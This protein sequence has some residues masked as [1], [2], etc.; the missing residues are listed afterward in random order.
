MNSD[1]ERWTVYPE[2]WTGDAERWTVK[3]VDP[4][5]AY[6]IKQ[7]SINYSRYGHGDGRESKDQL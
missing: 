5:T 1:G 4:W 7:T 6:C 2:R 3:D